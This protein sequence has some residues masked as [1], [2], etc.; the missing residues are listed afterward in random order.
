M[1]ASKI[2]KRKQ[3]ESELKKLMKNSHPVIAKRVKAILILNVMKI[4]EYPNVL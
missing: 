4:V 3:I 1:A 2:F